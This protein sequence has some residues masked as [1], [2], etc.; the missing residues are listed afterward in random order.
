MELGD[1][2]GIGKECRLGG[3]GNKLVMKGH[4][5]WFLKGK[6]GFLWLVLNWKGVYMGVE[7]G[8]KTASH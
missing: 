2:K 4:F 3:T 5:L 7:V 1:R 8:E 6:F